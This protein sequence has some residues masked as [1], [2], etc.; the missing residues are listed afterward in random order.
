M[1][2][3][4]KRE[5]EEDSVELYQLAVKLLISLLCIASRKFYIPGETM[6]MERLRSKSIECGFL[7]LMVW[8]LI[9]MFI[10]LHLFEEWEW[11]D[12]ERVKKGYLWF[13][14]RIRL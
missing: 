2:S 9:F 1:E 11:R 12:K 8:W 4:N 7:S 14:R 13:I 10:G 6:E 5:Y 3:C